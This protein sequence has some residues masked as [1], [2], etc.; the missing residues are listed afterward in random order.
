MPY[1]EIQNLTKIFDGFFAKQGLVAV[2]NVSLDIQRG[3]ILG[4]LGVNGAGKTTMLKMICGLL[5]PTSGEIRINGLELEKNRPTLLNHISAVLEGSRNSLW[6]MTVRQN[7]TYFGF[8]KNTHGQKLK[9]RGRNLLQFF[10]L[11]HKENEVVKNLSKGM[12]QKLAIVLAFISDPDLILL[13]EPTLG[14]DVQTAK[15]VKQR[16]VELARQKNKTILLTS[17]QIEMVEEICDRVAIINQGRIIAL[18]RTDKLLGQMGREQ[19]IFEF[20]EPPDLAA[21]EKLPELNGFEFSPTQ[22][23]GNHFCLRLVLGHCGNLTRALGA[24]EQHNLKILSISRSK[25][26]LEDIFLKMIEAPEGSN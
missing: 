10:Q 4:L 9:D 22:A 18:D 2:D 17:H 8:L 16:M 21:L 13:D 19:Y 14:L 23:D 24:F 26:S 15:L 11:E 1:V 25:P 12:K 5:K 7:L 6:S 3:E 20:E